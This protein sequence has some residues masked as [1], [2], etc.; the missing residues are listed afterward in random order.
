MRSGR[1]H[2][3]RIDRAVQNADVPNREDFAKAKD[4]IVASGMRSTG[5]NLLGMEIDFCVCLGDPP[6]AGEGD[7]CPDL[8][9]DMRISLS[10]GAEWLIT[11]RAHGRLADADAIA[12]QLSRMWDQMLRYPY[13]EAH[14]VSRTSDGVRLQAVTQMAPGGLWVTADVHVDLG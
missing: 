7:D 12:A 2:L 9:Q 5:D 10:E 8:W 6:S 11:G 13:R 4:A 1:N 14:I 3:E